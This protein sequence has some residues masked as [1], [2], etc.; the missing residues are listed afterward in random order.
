MKRILYIFVVLTLGSLA[1]S[2]TLADMARQARKNKPAPN[3]SR[4]VIT[5]ESLS[6]RPSDDST[7]SDTASATD[8]KTGDKTADKKDDKA[9]AGS[10]EDKK[11]LAEEWKSKIQKQSDEVATLKRELDIYQREAKLRAAAY[12]GDAG[13]KLR[14]EA[15]YAQEE[16]RQQTELANKQKAISNAEQ[17]LSQMRDE[18]RKAGVPPGMIP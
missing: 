11:K 10:E 9:A 17:K 7:S 13:N 1:S 2:Q 14:N 8:T 12:Y 3:P 5:N 4:Q 6:M 15:A 16:Q 18:A